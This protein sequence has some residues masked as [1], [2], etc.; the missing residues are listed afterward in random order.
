MSEH[1]SVT[2]LLTKKLIEVDATPDLSK[3]KPVV[4]LKPE[5][6]A[7]LLT[8]LDDMKEPWIA[9]KFNDTIFV[10]WNEL[11]FLHVISGEEEPSK[12]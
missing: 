9:M 8:N 5:E 3:H 2:P 6:F 11:I 4:I 12:E 7:K 10:I 1:E